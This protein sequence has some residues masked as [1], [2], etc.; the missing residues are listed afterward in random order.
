[1]ALNIYLVFNGNCRQAVE[2]YSQVFSTPVGEIMTFGD[3]PENSEFPLGEAEKKLIMH[4]YMRISG[5]IVMFSD[6]FPGRPVTMGDNVSITVMSSDLEE[7]K[8]QFHRIKEGGVVEMDLQETF[9]TQCYGS[10]RDQFGVN[11]QFSHK[12]E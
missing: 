10:V 9:W 1:M 6:T 2:F 8:T 11:W 3:G 4:T 12:E 5:D 7:L